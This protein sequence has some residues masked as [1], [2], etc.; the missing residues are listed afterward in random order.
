MSSELPL[1]ADDR[2]RLPAGRGRHHARGARGA[3]ARL[4][5]QPGRRLP[6]RLRRPRRGLLLPQRPRGRDPRPAARRPRA[7]RR[8]RGLRRAPG[9]RHRAHLPRRRHGL[10]ALDPPGARTT[11]R[12]RSAATSTSGSRTAPA[13]TSTWRGSS[14]ALERVWA[15]AP[16]LVLYQAGADPYRED[17]LGGL[18]ADARRASR[19]ATAWCSR[20]ARARGIPAVVTLG[21]GYARRLEDTVQIHLATCRLRARAGARA[22]GRARDPRLARRRRGRPAGEPAEAARLG[23]RRARAPCGSTSTASRGRRD[24]GRSRRSASIRWCSRTW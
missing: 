16:E 17:Q 13:T 1:T 4:R 5:R 23:A 20:A 11:R 21:G 18:G 7:A 15:S 9:Q 10:H 3:D 14:A 6:P 19:R 8:G 12:R 2:A 22:E 24:R